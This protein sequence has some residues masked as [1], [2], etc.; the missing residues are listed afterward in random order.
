MI[1]M[2]VSDGDHEDGRP[3]GN[4]GDGLDQGIPFESRMMYTEIIMDYYRNP[5]CFGTLDSPTFKA[6]DTNPSCGDIIEIQVLLDRDNVITDIKFSGKGCAISQAAASMLA[7]S[8]IGKP[9]EE[10]SRVGKEQVLEMIGIPVSMMRLKCALLGLKVL[11]VGAY[12][13]L[14]R[15]IEEEEP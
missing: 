4:A 12:K 9:L 14:G 3:D 1:A 10:V 15:E 2:Q 8:V 7:E 5:R 6:R 11:K 13:Y